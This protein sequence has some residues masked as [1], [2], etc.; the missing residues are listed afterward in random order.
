V[1]LAYIDDSRTGDKKNPF[2][3]MTAVIIEDKDFRSLEVRTGAIAKS[4]VPEEK[5]EQFEEFHAWELYRGCGVFE[6]VHQTQRFEVIKALLNGLLVPVIYGA[7]DKGRLA[8]TLYSSA[9]PVDM[10]FQ[11]CVEGIE[12]WLSQLSPPGLAILIVDDSTDRDIKKALRKS[13]RKIRQPLRAPVFPIGQAWHLHDDMYFS[14]SKES[15]GIQSA[16][17]CGFF[18]NK[19]LKG[20]DLAAEGFYKIIEDRIVC[21]RMEPNEK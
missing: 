6:G 4:I 2:Q 15:I 12:K 11:I 10:C 7:V 5:W 1:H 8:K 19:H 9:D 18:I 16:D 3:V 20:T 14:D 17:L 13:F 21:S